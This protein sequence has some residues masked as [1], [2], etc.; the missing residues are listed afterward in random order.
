MSKVYLVNIG[1]NAA[2]SSG[3]RSPIFDDGSFVYVPFPHPGTP[4]ARSYPSDARPF[5]RGLDF[6]HTHV[7]PDWPNLTYGDDTSY[8]RARALKRVLSGDTLLFWGLLWRNRGH[9]WGDFTG[10]RNWYF[11]GALR[12]EEILAGGESAKDATPINRERAEQNVHSYGCALGADERVFFGS[13]SHSQLFSRAVDLQT[14][15]PSG[16]LFRTITTAHGEPLSLNGAVRWN[17]STRS[18]RAIWDLADPEQRRRAQ[19][20][21]D[22]ILE[23]SGYDLF[24]D[25]EN[26]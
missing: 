5:T 20:A 21:R 6:S 7:D 1:A 10:E 13:R 18:C 26:A 15:Q 17:S 16:L 23:R 8:A 3:A 22:V 9:G 2:H 11:I 19:I 4:G 14:T 25:T 24:R 12:V